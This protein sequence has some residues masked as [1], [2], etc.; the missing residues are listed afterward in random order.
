MTPTKSI[1]FLEA[2]RCLPRQQQEELANLFYQQPE[3]MARCQRWFYAKLVAGRNADTNGLAAIL[4]EEET[5]LRQVIAQEQ[6]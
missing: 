3:M 2:L 6:Q 5:Y 4:K 1:S